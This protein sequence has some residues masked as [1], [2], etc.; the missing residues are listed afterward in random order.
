MSNEQEYE[1]LK[2]AVESLLEICEDCYHKYDTCKTI[3]AIL[4]IYNQYCE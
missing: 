4:D 1:D 3:T 2:W